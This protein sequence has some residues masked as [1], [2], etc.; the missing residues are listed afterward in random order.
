MKTVLAIAAHPDDI[1]FVMAGTLMR[2]KSAGYKL[3]YWNLANGCCGSTVT[4]RE[5]TARI[6]RLEGMAAAE[7]VGATFHES[8]C[9]DL[10]IFYNQ[11]TL[12]KVA[13]VIR[14]VAPTIVLT[15]ALHDY[16]EDHMNAARLA[17]TGAFC[18]GMPNFPVSPHRE[19]VAGYV[20]VYH[21]QPHGN[22][23]PMGEVV[24]PT[25]FVDVTELIDQKCEMLAQHASQKL[26]LDESQ[27]QDSYLET[28]KQLNGEV[29]RMSARFDYAEGW[30]RHLHFGFCGEHD[31]PLAEAL[32]SH[33]IERE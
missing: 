18:R 30:R 15:H 33:V 19:P 7:F 1:E 16:M 13:S 2:L 28:M 9:A 31:D 4:D 3:H 32:G 24:V 23:T 29:G 8:I 11:A 27:G 26:W 20:T 5:E 22:R 14:E 21:A 12:A 6:R 10:E 17:V 25:Q